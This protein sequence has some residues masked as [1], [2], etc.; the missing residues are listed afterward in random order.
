MN[1]S[2]ISGFFDGEGYISFHE[3]HNSS[4][5]ESGEFNYRYG[6]RQKQVYGSLREVV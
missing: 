2:Y 1:W 3:K 5:A 6:H 4:G